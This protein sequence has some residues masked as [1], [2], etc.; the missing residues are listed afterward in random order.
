MTAILHIKSSS[1]LQGSFTRQ[2]GAIAVERLKAQHPHAQI[3]ERDLVASPVPHITPEW[4]GAAFSGNADAAALKLSNTLVDEVFASDILVIEAP[5][6]NFSVPSVLKAW[7]DQVVRAG[8]TFSHSASGPEGLVKGKRAIVVFGAG[9]FYAEGPYK[10]YEHTLSYLLSVLGFIGITNVETIR[11][12]GVALGQDKVAE[13]LE[14]AKKQA[15][16][17]AA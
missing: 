14:K 1:N 13:A 11:I 8:K 10:P 4:I 12:E 16:A 3:I 9:G 15:N 17:L 2:I 5:M 6:Y 7:I